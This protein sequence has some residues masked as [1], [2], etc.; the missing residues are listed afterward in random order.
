MAGGSSYGSGSALAGSARRGRPRSRFCPGRIHRHRSRLPCCGCWGTC[1]KERLRLAAGNPGTVRAGLGLTGANTLPKPRRCELRAGNQPGFSPQTES[2][3]DPT[4]QPAYTLRPPMA[5]QVT[6]RLHREETNRSRYNPPCGRA[7]VPGTSNPPIVQPWSA[8]ATDQPDMFT[9]RGPSAVRHPRRCNGSGFRCSDASEAAASP[10]LGP[11]PGEPVP[12]NPS[13][14]GA[15]GAC[16]KWPLSALAVPIGRLPSGSGWLPLPDAGVFN[17]PEP[18]P[19]VG[20]CRPEARLAMPV[21]RR[22]RAAAQH[23][24]RASTRLFASFV[25]AVHNGVSAWHRLPRFPVYTVQP[26]SIRAR[27]DLAL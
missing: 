20:N 9:R 14:C 5:E 21:P 26:P 2:S 25:Q 7:A 24:A 15:C 10:G 23:P 8:K 1:R 19:T 12:A 18:D 16:S 3:A 13:P 4:V 27:N 22:I 6:C 11:D 17:H